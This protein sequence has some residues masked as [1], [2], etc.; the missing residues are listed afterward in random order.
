MEDRTR[1]HVISIIVTTLYLIYSLFTVFIF[2]KMV[3]IDAFQYAGRCVG[4]QLG[5]IIKRWIC[6]YKYSNTF[7]YTL[8]FTLQF[9]VMYL[10]T[11]GWRPVFILNMSLLV[12][13]FL[14]IFF[15][16]KEKGRPPAPS[17]TGMYSVPHPCP[18]QAADTYPEVS[19]PPA[20]CTLICPCQ[21]TAYPSHLFHVLCPPVLSSV[22]DPCLCQAVARCP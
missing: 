21:S 9:T 2:R 22:P 15:L 12:A 6:I 5:A 8:L 19:C 20:L 14:Y 11:Y 10:S 7:C 1:Q 3:M 16:V 4:V 18:C 13:T 17:S